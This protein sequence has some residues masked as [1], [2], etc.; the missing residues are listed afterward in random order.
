MSLVRCTDVH[1]IVLVIR[2]TLGQM[3]KTLD[4]DI[5]LESIDY[6]ASAA[7][8]MEREM[9]FEGRDCEADNEHMQAI[10]FVVSAIY[11]DGSSVIDESK[12]EVIAHKSRCSFLDVTQDELQTAGRS[13]VLHN[14]QMVSS[15]NQL[16][17][18]QTYFWFVNEKPEVLIELDEIREDGWIAFYVL[19]GPFRLRK[20]IPLSACGVLP[21]PDGLWNIWNWLERVG[22][23]P[24]QDK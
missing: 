20:A 6:I 9:N 2:E 18:G 15:P 24:K 8:A 14:K 19:T 3:C 17:V 1:G 12:L 5:D 21:Y 10:R 13:Q 4:M 23:R 22:P 11:F 16:V 7:R